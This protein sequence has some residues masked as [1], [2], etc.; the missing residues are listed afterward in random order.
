M[1]WYTIPQ[2]PIKQNHYK[3]KYSLNRTTEEPVL[4][5]SLRDPRVLL[6]AAEAADIYGPYFSPS[7]ASVFQR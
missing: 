1:G 6:G 5:E 7:D 3:T 2:G 4:Y